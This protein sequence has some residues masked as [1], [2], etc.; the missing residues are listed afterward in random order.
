[1]T[2]KQR[3]EVI[4]KV[5]RGEAIPDPQRAAVCE[6]ASAVLARSAPSGRPLLRHR[7]FSYA[8]ALLEG[9]GGPAGLIG[10]SSIF[11]G[12]PEYDGLPAVQSLAK[13]VQ[14]TYR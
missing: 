14:A 13:R 4:R 3:R 6:W 12:D 9:A 1:M 2:P 11:D 8:W 7:I 5:R 10:T